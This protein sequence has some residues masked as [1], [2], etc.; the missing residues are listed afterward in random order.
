M[1]LKTL[2]DEQPQLNLTSMIDVLFLLI[3]FFMLATK[4]SDQE[5]SIDVHVPQVGDAAALTEAPDRRTINLYRDGRISLDRQFVTLEELTAQLAAA[6][7]EYAQLG[8]TVRG[9]ADGRF[10]HVADV[11]DACRRAGVNDMAIAVRTEQANVAEAPR[12]ATR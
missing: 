1:P 6:R 10:Q 9:D 5:R 8:V 7:A 4:F 3:I 2:V 12:A 11:L